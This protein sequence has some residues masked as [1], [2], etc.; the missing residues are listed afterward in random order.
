MLAVDLVV[1]ADIEQDDLLFG[2]HNGEGDAVAVSEAHR[3]H[4]LQLAGQ[5]VILQVGLE[6]V[7]FQVAQGSGEFSPQFRMM[8]HEL[9]SR[10]GEAGGPDQG[11][12]A[13]RP[14]PVP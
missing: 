8:F 2:H 6:R 7:A 3:L 4:P 9:F 12:H 13:S 14:D 5:V 10:T 1:A 11:I